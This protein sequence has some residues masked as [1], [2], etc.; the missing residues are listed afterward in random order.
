[1][2]CVKNVG[3]ARFGGIELGAQSMS[4]HVRWAKS[5]TLGATLILMLYILNKLQDF[6]NL[7]FEK[8]YMGPVCRWCLARSVWTSPRC[9]GITIEV[10]HLLNSHIITKNERAWSKKSFPPRIRP[11]I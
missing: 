8:Y 9:T 4:R 1:M 7:G 5:M 2:T 3:T 6:Q 10:E 11:Q